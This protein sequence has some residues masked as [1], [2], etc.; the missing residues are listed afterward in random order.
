MERFLFQKVF[1]TS[2]D[3]TIHPPKQACQAFFAKFLKKIL[4]AKIP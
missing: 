3:A 2:D 1:S 4:S